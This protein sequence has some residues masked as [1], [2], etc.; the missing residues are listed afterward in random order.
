MVGVAA[1]AV[2]GD[3]GVRDGRSAAGVGRSLEHE[4]HAPFAQHEAVAAAVERPRR[5][6]RVVV[7]PRQGAQV[8][9][10]RQPDRRDRQVA[11]ARHADVDQA[12]PQPVPADL[13]RVVAAG[14]GRRQRQRRP[15][16]PQRTPGPLD[17]RLPVLLRVVEPAPAGEVVG[18]PEEHPLGAQAE[19]QPDPRV[20]VHAPEPGVAQG[21]LGAPVRELVQRRLA[22]ERRGIAAGRRG[23]RP[24]LRGDPA[25]VVVGREPRHRRH[26]RPA[27]PAGS[28][29]SPPARSPAGS[30]P[31]RP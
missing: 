13:Q 4:R 21:R 6:G 9:E 28:T 1:G 10:R 5:R 7:P 3:L 8:A 15:G 24:E 2:A 25:G 20:A 17:R 31:P 14:A 19:H 29:R 12:Q 16:E 27:R 26:P 23:D 11:G 22:R 30:R 18:L